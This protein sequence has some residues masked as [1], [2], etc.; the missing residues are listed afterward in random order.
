MR[1]D[2]V[3]EAETAAERSAAAIVE[4]VREAET[5]SAETASAETASAET[6]SAET[7]SAET[8]SAETASAERSAQLRLLRQ[9]CATQRVRRGGYGGA[10][11]LGR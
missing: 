1:E 9:Q 2:A 4:A 8:A 5:A 7:A 11:G 3:S 10:R 6:A